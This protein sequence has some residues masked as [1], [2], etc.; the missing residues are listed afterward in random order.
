MTNHLGPK[1]NHTLSPISVESDSAPWNVEHF[2][3]A[4]NPELAGL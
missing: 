3:E 2:S 1:A 4:G